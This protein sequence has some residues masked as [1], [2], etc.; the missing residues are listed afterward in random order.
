[1]IEARWRQRSFADGFLTEQVD[2]FWDDWM[3]AADQV[4]DDDALVAT[5]AEALG[6]RWP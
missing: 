4:L 2:E 1:V 6:K 3:R 5:V